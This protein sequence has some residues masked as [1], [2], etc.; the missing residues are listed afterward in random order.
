[1]T[2]V[3]IARIGSEEK[4]EMVSLTCEYVSVVIW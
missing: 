1:V 4:L 3:G 2:H